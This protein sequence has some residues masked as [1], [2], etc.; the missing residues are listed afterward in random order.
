MILIEIYKN[1]PEETEM[2]RNKFNILKWL[3]QDAFL[4]NWGIKRDEGST[5]QLGL[6]DFVIVQNGINITH[7]LLIYHIKFIKLLIEMGKK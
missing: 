5:V 2:L 3:R 7:L 6:Q 1:L 4:I